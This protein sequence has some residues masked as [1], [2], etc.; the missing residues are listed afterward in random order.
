VLTVGGGGLSR[1]GPGYLVSK[2]LHVAERMS[3]VNDNDVTVVIK[4]Q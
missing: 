2:P 4:I 3:D 1:A